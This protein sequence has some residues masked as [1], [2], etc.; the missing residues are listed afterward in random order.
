IHTGADD[1][2]RLAIIVNIR[3]RAGGNPACGCVRQAEAAVKLSAPAFQ[4]AASKFL[5]QPFAV[6]WMKRAD[7]IVQM[8]S[9][10]GGDAVETQPFGSAPQPPSPDLP[11]EQTDPRGFLSALMP[12]MLRLRGKFKTLLVLNIRHRAE[13]LRNPPVLIQNRRAFE[14][15]PP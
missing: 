2:N 5:A 10:R 1:T 11:F 13:P 6:I 14:E 8:Q 3:C 15:K 12:L 9:G 4:T 7:P